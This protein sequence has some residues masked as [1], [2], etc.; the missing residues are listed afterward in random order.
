MNF[1]VRGWKA[2]LTALA[3]TLL[4]AGVPSLGH[5]T[6]LNFDDVS[7]YTLLSSYGGLNWNNFFVANTSTS[8]GNY[9]N[10]ASSGTQFVYNGSYMSASVASSGTFTFNSAYFDSGWYNGLTVTVTG[11]NGSTTVDTTSFV[12]NTNGGPVLETF[13]WTGLTELDFSS[14]GGTEYSGYVGEGGATN[15][16]IDDFTFNNPTTTA[17]P[18]PASL[19]LLV[20]GAAGIGGYAWRRRNM[21]AAKLALASQASA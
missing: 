9:S 3:V 20:L 11:K 21:A 12:L 5:A 10:A 13:N 18:E 4:M 1:N 16:T 7:N 14:Y 17:T 6:T 8:V 15:Y 19:T 2:L